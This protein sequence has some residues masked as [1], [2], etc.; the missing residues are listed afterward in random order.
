MVEPPFSNASHE[1]PSLTLRPASD[2][3]SL[4]ARKTKAKVVSLTAVGGNFNKA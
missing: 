1:K 2:I 4:Y 3:A